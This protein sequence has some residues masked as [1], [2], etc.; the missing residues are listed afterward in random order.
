MDIYNLSKVPNTSEYKI[1]SQGVTKKY[2]LTMEEK[3]MLEKYKDINRGNYIMSYISSF[4]GFSSVGICLILL[5][6]SYTRNYALYSLPVIIG[7]WFTYA[8]YLTNK[9]NTNAAEMDALLKE[10]QI[11]I[12]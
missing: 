5:F 3:R 8:Y 9:G 2:R 4:L 10:T 12:F 11:R 7:L 1:F 6:P